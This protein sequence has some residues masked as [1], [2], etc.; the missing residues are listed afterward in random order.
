MM[1]VKKLMEYLNRSP[2]GSLGALASDL[3]EDPAE[4]RAFI[5]AADMPVSLAERIASALEIPAEE[6]G[7]V[8]FAKP[9]AFIL[10]PSEY[11]VR[12]PALNEAEILE[13]YQVE[14]LKGACSF[15]DELHVAWELSGCYPEEIPGA[16]KAAVDAAEQAIPADAFPEELVAGVEDAATMHGFALGVQFAAALLKEDGPLGTLFRQELGL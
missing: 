7:S 3:G 15:L 14:G 10:A 13:R 12:I 4:L 16:L 6:W 11:S 8:F 5:A 9:A 2:I 1:N